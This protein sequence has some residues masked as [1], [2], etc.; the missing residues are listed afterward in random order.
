MD[1]SVGAE[2]RGQDI[3]ML[4]IDRISRRLNGLMWSVDP[5]GGPSESHQ[6]GLC[7]EPH[8]GLA[9]NA[10]VDRSIWQKICFFGPKAQSG[11]IPLYFPGLSRYSR[12]GRQLARGHFYVS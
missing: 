3:S 7:G 11:P 12:A 2:V 8:R 10:E 1:T 5:I 9:R 4:S 6:S